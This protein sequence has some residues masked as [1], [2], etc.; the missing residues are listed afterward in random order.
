MYGFIL[1][2]FELICNQ[3]PYK[4]ILMYV[5]VRFYVVVRI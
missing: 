1:Y 5:H 2:Y 4:R 3:C